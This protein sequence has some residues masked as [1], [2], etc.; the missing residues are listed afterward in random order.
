MPKSIARARR[1]YSECTKG[2]DSRNIMRELQTRGIAAGAVQNARDLVDDDPQL[3]HRRHWVS[4]QHP[5][6]GLA[7]YNAPPCTVRYAGRVSRPAPLL[8]E[9]T[10]EICREL[11]A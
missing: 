2:M 1:R 9:H 8:G 3:A 7:V 6:M 11:R 4:L 10:E 5:E